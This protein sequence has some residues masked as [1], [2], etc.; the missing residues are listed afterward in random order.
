LV[1]ELH[2]PESGSLKD[3]RM[4]L[5]RIRD[6][7]ASRRD[8]SFAEVGYQDLWQRSR[9]L[10]AVA[11]SD[12]ARLEETLERIRQYLDGQEW[13]LTAYETEVVDVDA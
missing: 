9:V 13:V 4:H 6:H 11:S 8:A 5:R 3:K 2:F 1:A 7:L 10:V 12:V